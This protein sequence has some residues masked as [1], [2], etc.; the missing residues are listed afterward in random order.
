M[1]A[2]TGDNVEK[3]FLAVV[4]AAAKRVKEDEP[5]I[6]DTLKLDT[7]KSTKEAGCAC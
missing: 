5:H 6:P 4:M 7:V 2:K 1:S 3:G